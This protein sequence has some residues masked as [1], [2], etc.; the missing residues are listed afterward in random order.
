MG[1]ICLVSKLNLTE[2]DWKLNIYR[3]QW[4]IVFIR[5]FDSTGLNIPWRRKSPCNVPVDICMSNYAFNNLVVAT[6]NSMNT[7]TCKH[8][9]TEVSFS[10]QWSLLTS[11]NLYM[12][13]T[14]VAQW[15]RALAPQADGWVF[16][17]QQ[18]QTLVVKI[19][20]DSSTAK[21]S[22]IGVIVTCRP[23]WPL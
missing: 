4:C 15:V 6:Q 21:C 20:H 7:W 3:I 16:K 13:T 18:R 12:F 17:S 2:L 11:I 9:H 5:A 14:T 22:A 19:C 23:R 10:D 1:E 8:Y